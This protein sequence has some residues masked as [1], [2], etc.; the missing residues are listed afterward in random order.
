MVNRKKLGITF[1]FSL[2]FFLISL[3][4]LVAYIIRNGFISLLKENPYQFIL[5]ILVISLSMAIFSFHKIIADIRY[6][7]NEERKKEKTVRDYY[8]YYRSYTPPDI[9]N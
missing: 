9:N 2:E 1:I 7:I 5:I 6:E 4:L 3:F 8:N